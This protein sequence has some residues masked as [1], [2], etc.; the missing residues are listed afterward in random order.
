MLRYVRILLYF[1][2]TTKAMCNTL[3]G[4]VVVSVPIKTRT[5]LRQY[6]SLPKPRKFVSTRFSQ[7]SVETPRDEGLETVESQTGLE[8]VSWSVGHSL[9][10]PK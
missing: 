4:Y 2:H 1:P 9:L 6:I 7:D 10:D 8:R 3:V 5:V